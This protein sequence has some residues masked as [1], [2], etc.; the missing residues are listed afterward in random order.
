VV[1]Q[2]LAARLWPG[3]DPIGQRLQYQE[4]PDLWL[5]VVGVSAPVLHHELDGQAGFD[6][7]RPYRQ[8]SRAGPY[9]VIRTA[10]D[11]LGIARAATAIIGETDSNQSFLD[12][13][14]YPHR[15]ANRIWQ[16]RLAGTLFGVFAAVAMF[17]AAIGLYGV[18]SYM[19]SQQTG[20]IAVRLAL[21]ATEGSILRTVLGR[22]LRLA[23]I[24]IAIGVVLAV[25]QTRLIANLLFGVTP[26]DPMTFA[27]VPIA[28]PAIAMLACYVPARRA[29]RVDPLVALRSQ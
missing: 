20:E 25:V 15:V 5:T 16:R 24:G 22:G 19:V 11:S 8:A 17:L 3:R 10:G 6:V 29:T 2:S 9:Y 12:V 4:M 13:L 1:S 14:T 21:G 7:Y 28:L 27:L 26:F 18:L 23:V